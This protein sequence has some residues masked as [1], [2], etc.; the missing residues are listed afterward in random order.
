MNNEALDL[1]GWS[2][3]CVGLV[4]LFYTV[5]LWSR[6]STWRQTRATRYMLS[7]VFF[8]AL[9]GVCGIGFAFTKSFAFISAG[10]ITSHGPHFS[11]R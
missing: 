5:L 1:I 6:G 2:Y 10:F 9:W 3:A 11:W 8:S 7:A 4:Y